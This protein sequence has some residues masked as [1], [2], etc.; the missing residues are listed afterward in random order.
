[1]IG[2]VYLAGPITG[3]T[4]R[5]ARGWRKRACQLL[6]AGGLD[7]FDP[8]DG[9]RDD[10]SVVEAAPRADVSDA[11]LVARCRAAL[12]G[13]VAMI[14]L[15]AGDRLSLGTVVELGWADAFGVPVIGIVARGSAYDHPFARQI[16]AYPCHTLPQAVLIARR[17]AAESLLSR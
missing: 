9:L 12:A 3:L 8:T 13:S 5:R 14:A 15:L 4:L 7:A 17:L 11:D 2:T 6:R 10:G 1:L 16:V